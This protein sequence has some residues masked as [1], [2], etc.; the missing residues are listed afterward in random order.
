MYSKPSAQRERSGQPVQSFFNELQGGAGD[1]LEPEPPVFISVVAWSV[2]GKTPLSWRLLSAD[3]MLSGI[4]SGIQKIDPRGS[5]G[6][7]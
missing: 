4:A 7:R 3:E 5:T 1:L 6:A 2:S